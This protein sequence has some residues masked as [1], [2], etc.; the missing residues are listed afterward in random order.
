MILVPKR[1]VWTPPQ[2]PSLIHAVLAAGGGLKVPLAI[3][4]IT[5]ATSGNAAVTTVNWSHTCTGSDR[6]LIVLVG[7]GDAFFGFSSNAS[8]S[9]AGIPM[10]LVGL[11]DFTNS[12]AIIFALIDPP[13]GPNTVAA[14][15]V[16]QFQRGMAAVSFT[17]AARSLGALTGPFASSGGVVNSAP[18]TVTSNVGEI[19]LNVIGTGFGDTN[20]GCNQP[21]IMQQY[22]PYYPYGA[23]RA[24]GASPSVNF[25]WNVNIAGGGGG[26]ES[27]WA[28]VSVKGA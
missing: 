26:A 12:A 20:N 14:T 7:E 24:V 25:T 3:D 15:E 9:Y 5:Q 16:N 2:R 4:A 17:G 10:T 11:R 13:T 27:A 23:A 22:A 18:L 19:A 21:I 1:R 6:A 8:C 28:G